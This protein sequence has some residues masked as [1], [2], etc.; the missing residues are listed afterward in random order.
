MSSGKC[1]CKFQNTW[2]TDKRFRAWIRKS[3]NG[4]HTA[5]CSFWQKSVSVA[6]QGIKQLEFHMNGEKHKHKTPPDPAASKQ[7]T[8]MFA[9]T[10][11]PTGGTST[12]KDNNEKR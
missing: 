9:S 4:P 3:E 8:L 2:L 1:N 12:E 11:N 7:K 6:R 5:F 10:S